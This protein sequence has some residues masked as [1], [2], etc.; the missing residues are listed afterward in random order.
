MQTKVPPSQP[1]PHIQLV[2]NK[3]RKNPTKL[4][5]VWGVQRKQIK[6]A[7]QLSFMIWTPIPSLM[8]T[9]HSV[10]PQPTSVQ[11]TVCVWYYPGAKYKRRQ[12][13]GASDS[14]P[15]SQTLPKPPCVERRRGDT[16]HQDTTHTAPPRPCKELQ[17]WRTHSAL[18]LKGEPRLCV[19]LW[20]LHTSTSQTVVQ[21][22]TLLHDQQ[23]S[24]PKWQYTQLL[25]TRN[26]SFQI[27]S[28]ASHLLLRPAA[29]KNPFGYSEQRN[30]SWFISSELWFHVRIAWFLFFRVQKRSLTFSLGYSSLWETRKEEPCKLICT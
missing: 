29:P 10:P 8:K 15:D 9:F 30:S 20:Y 14:I 1:L 7:H 2:K 12:E 3:K 6:H 17:A 27:P 19:S 5:T 21:S 4:F 28:A 24:I 23:S 13:V 22:F 11:R 16:S 26:P 18:E 25:S